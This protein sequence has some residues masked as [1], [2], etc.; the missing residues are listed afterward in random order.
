MLTYLELMPV[1]SCRIGDKYVN[2]ANVPPYPKIVTR[3][4]NKILPFAASFSCSLTLG[5]VVAF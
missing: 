5:A 1:I 4:T 2:V 3:R